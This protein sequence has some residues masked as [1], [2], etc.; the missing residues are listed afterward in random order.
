MAKDR[1]LYSFKFNI[2]EIHFY[3]YT[4]NIIV[5]NFIRS[6]FALYPDGFLN[7]SNIAK[8]YFFA[9]YEPITINIPAFL[10]KELKENNAPHTRVRH[11]WAISVDKRKILAISKNVAYCLIKIPIKNQLDSFYYNYLHPLMLEIWFQNG[12]FYCHGAGILHRKL[13]PLILIGPRGSGKT[14]LTLFFLKNG[15]RILSDDTL[16]FRLNGRNV[17]IFSLLRPL[18]ADP[19]LTKIL[20]MEDQFRNK[21]EYLPNAN[22]V[23]LN[24]NILFAGQ[25]INQ[26]DWPKAI[27]FP[28]IN[29]G[30]TSIKDAHPILAVLRILTQ[31]YPGLQRKERS[32]D[33]VQFMKHLLTV[34]MIDLV[35]CKDALVNTR[36]PLQLLEARL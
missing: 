15:H 13:G 19:T 14:T 5:R 21:N 24:A 25:I 9:I 16:L 31:C 30:I 6:I 11:H 1:V 22:R 23:A 20:G 17:K 12:L 18:H 28:Q 35:L 36:L 4:N 10:N 8:I 27:I 33:F 32:S 26:L 2:A 3:M 34:P 29:S 7:N